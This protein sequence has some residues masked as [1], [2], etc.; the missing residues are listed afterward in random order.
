M[1]DTSE[2]YRLQNYT[3]AKT[4]HRGMHWRRKN[5]HM[6]IV[7]CLCD[8]IMGGLLVCR[9]REAPVPILQVS[10]E[11]TVT[12]LANGGARIGSWATY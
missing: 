5:M 1:D 10:K 8:G 7:G 12:E 3:A 9:T 2:K 11:P 6:L 4:T